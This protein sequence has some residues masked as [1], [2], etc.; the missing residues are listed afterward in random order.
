MKFKDNL[1]LIVPSNIKNKLIEEIR[2][3]N[4]TYAGKTAKPEGLYLKNV[5]Y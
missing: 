1:V 3:E 5:F 2:K 4:R